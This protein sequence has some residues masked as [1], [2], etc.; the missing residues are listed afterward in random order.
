MQDPIISLPAGTDELRKPIVE[1]DCQLG[2]GFRVNDEGKR[3]VVGTLC[4]EKGSTSVREMDT[5][6]AGCAY[7]RSDIASVLV[8]YS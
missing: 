8:L 5:P 4:F 2:I 1:G 6:C 7:S 3:K